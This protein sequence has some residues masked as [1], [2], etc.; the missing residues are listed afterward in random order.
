[1]LGI[2][3]RHFIVHINVNTVVPMKKTLKRNLSSLDLQIS[4]G[5]VK[6]MILQIKS[7]SMTSERTSSGQL[8]KQLV[9]C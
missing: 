8:M 1:M 7:R 4:M 3:S 6:M 9:K 5:G 2:S